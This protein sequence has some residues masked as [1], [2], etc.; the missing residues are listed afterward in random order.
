MTYFYE[1]LRQ[2]IA[3]RYNFF[4]LDYLCKRISSKF[5]CGNVGVKDDIF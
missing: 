4:M 1:V 3:T 5:W 2:L